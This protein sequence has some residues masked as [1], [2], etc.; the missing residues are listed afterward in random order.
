[1]T[2]LIL[3][4]P[5]KLHSRDFA[6]TGSTALCPLPFIVP[7]SGK[8]LSPP[9]LYRVSKHLVLLFLGMQ[10]FSKYLNVIIINKNAFLLQKVASYTSIYIYDWLSES[11]FMLK[12]IKTLKHVLLFTQIIQTIWFIGN[13]K[14]TD[15]SR[16]GDFLL[17]VWGLF[18]FFVLYN[19]MWILPDADLRLL[20]WESPTPDKLLSILHHLKKN[21][22]QNSAICYCTWQ[23]SRRSITGRKQH[24]FA[25]FRSSFARR[26]TYGLNSLWCVPCLRTSK[27]ESS[28]ASGIKAQRYLSWDNTSRRYPYWTCRLFC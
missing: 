22:K 19:Y 10:Q 8:K 4:P 28:D 21:P 6:R 18:L 5:Y 1:M 13:S 17:L 24:T 16:F 27:P 12:C 3:L 2:T 9:W 15:H 14:V 7:A 11:D 26:T 25:F 23:F 20:Q